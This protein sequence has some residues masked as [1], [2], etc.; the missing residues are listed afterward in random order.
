MDYRQQIA[1]TGRP[2]VSSPWATESDLPPSESSPVRT[3]S[4]FGDQTFIRGSREVVDVHALRAQL[5]QHT[6][7]DLLLGAFKSIDGDGTGTVTAAQYRRVFDN[8]AP[9]LPKSVS[10]Q[11]MLL[12]SGGSGLVVYGSVFRALGHEGC[13]RGCAVADEHPVFRQLQSRAKG[14]SGDIIAHRDNDDFEASEVQRPGSY[15]MA[16][17]TS[18][19]IIGHTSPTRSAEV[20]W[21]SKGRI[22][23]DGSGSVLEYSHPS[24][25]TVHEHTAR[26]SGY[27]NAGDI[28]GQ[29]DDAYADPAATRKMFTTQLR[30]F[31]HGYR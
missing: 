29:T 11:I 20:D 15:A 25:T 26:Y 23:P 24:I 17:T 19:D 31:N 10:S 4:T 1:A 30:K 9:H 7:L 16:A 22:M 12:G 5:L 28:I 8:L 27:R 2:V 13:G 3:C 14:T 6:N 21:S 18:G